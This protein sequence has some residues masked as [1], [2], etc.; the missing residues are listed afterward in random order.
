LLVTR[1]GVMHFHFTDLKSITFR[2]PA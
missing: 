1:C 2:L